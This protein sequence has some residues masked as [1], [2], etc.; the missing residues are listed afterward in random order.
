MMKYSMVRKFL[1]ELWLIII[2]CYLL[3]LIVFSIAIKL[4]IRNWYYL[5]ARY[6]SIKISSIGKNGG[7]GRAINIGRQASIGGWSI[8]L[9]V[10]NV[11]QAE[12]A[13][14]IIFGKQ[15]SIHS[16]YDLLG[17][18]LLRK[19]ASILRWQVLVNLNLI[20]EHSGGDEPA[21]QVLDY[22]LAITVRHI[23]DRDLGW[24]VALHHLNI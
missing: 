24:Q 18:I 10:G 3:I 11:G 9:R 20:F 23:V 4:N 22:E 8:G 13:G 12:L 2:D 21:I 6:E 16:V 5:F 19:A 1:C 15:G 7:D 17:I 14:A